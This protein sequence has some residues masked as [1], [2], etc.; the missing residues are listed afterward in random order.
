MSIHVIIIVNILNS[1]LIS[2]LSLY[3]VES[4]LTCTLNL[5]L[6]GMEAFKSLRTFCTRPWNSLHTFEAIPD[7]SYDRYMP[8]SVGVTF[9]FGCN[10]MYTS[11]P[12]SHCGDL[13]SS[14]N[15]F[16]PI[17]C[18]CFIR[19]YMYAFVLGRRANA[20][21][22]SGTFIGPSIKPSKKTVSVVS[23]KSFVMVSSWES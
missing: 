6:N 11:R 18:D 10:Y 17:H 14:A 7:F 22:T 12:C 8:W 4:V 20:T 19:M 23:W 5:C 13:I 16:H 2:E 1:V 21:D 15:G 3:T 9:M